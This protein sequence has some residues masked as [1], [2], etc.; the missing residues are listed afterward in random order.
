VLWYCHQS[1]VDV[2]PGQHVEPGDV[3]G[4]IGD[5]GNTT[6]PHLHLE[7]HPH[8]GDPVDPEVALR[9]WGLRP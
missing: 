3:I 9:S 4:A 6:G 2:S 1:D 8:G 7:V 5:S